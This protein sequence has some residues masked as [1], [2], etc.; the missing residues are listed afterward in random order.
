VR[1]HRFFLVWEGT[2]TTETLGSFLALVG[3]GKTWRDYNSKRSFERQIPCRRL[4][5]ELGTVRVKVAFSHDPLRFCP[6]FD[7]LF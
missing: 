6:T 4:G 7:D 3:V 5:A 1:K 2:R